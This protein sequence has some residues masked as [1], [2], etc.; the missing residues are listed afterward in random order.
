MR[1]GNDALPL[2]GQDHDGWFLHDRAGHQVRKIERPP[3][4][5]AQ[6]R[7]DFRV[8]DPLQL[9]PQRLA[10]I[11][12]QRRALQH[13][14]GTAKAGRH[15]DQTHGPGRPTDQQRGVGR[16]TRPG[17]IAYG[18]RAVDAVQVLACHSRDR[19][20]QRGHAALAKAAVG[21]QAIAALDAT[22]AICRSHETQ[23]AAADHGRGDVDVGLLRGVC[24]EKLKIGEGHQL[25]IPSA[26]GRQ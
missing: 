12:D 17:E 16:A 7:A 18:R 5:Q 23:G 9:Q 13:C 24:E 1:Y 15:F 26:M 4:R 3:R 14:E 21:G 8:G 19:L 6:R 11:H 20:H 25:V 2:R 10:K 22:W